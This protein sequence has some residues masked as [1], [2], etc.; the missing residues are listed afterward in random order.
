[1]S[2]YVNQVNEQVLR[3]YVGARTRLADEQGQRAA[4]YLGIVVVV[5]AIV[6][7]IA[8]MGTDIGTSVGDFIQDQIDTIGG[9]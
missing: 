8:T 7:A 5:A 4:E 1:M 6:G 9:E 3:L 2:E